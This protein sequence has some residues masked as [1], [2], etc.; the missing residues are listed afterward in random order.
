MGLRRAHRGWM[1]P[2]ATG[3]AFL[4]AVSVTG[5]K[6]DAPASRG[7]LVAGSVFVPVMPPL[8]P[9]TAY[10][11]GEP[12]TPGYGDGG[13]SGIF[14]ETVMAH[15]TT[16][17]PAPVMNHWFYLVN[18]TGLPAPGPNGIRPTPTSEPSVLTVNGN[19]PT[20][21]PNPN[22]GTAV[23]L[24]ALNPAQTGRQLWK[25]VAAANGNF[26]LRS[27]ESFETKVQSGLSATS[28]LLG[29]GSTSAML[30]LGNVP[31]YHTGPV[32]AW[33]QSSSP[34]GDQSA[35]QQWSYDTGNGQLT[36]A[37]GGQLYLDSS[38]QLV[39]GTGS[40]SPG[41]QWYAVPTYFLEAVVAQANSSPPFPA[42]ATPGETAAY[43]Y[44][45]SQLLGSPGASETCN[46]EGTTYS[47]IRCQY[48]NVNATS[49]LTGCQISVGKLP[50]PGTFE[51][52]TIAPSDWTSVQG[53][54]V[55]EC[56]YAAD[57]QTTFANYKTFLDTLFV[58]ES[59]SI[60]GLAGDVG[61][62]QATSLNPVPIEILE[63]IVYTVLCA[64]G[65]P[66]AGVI[67][68]VISTAT[69]AAL[70]APGQTLTHP[71]ATTV[72]SI[73]GD[74]GSA[75]ASL[76]QGLATAET[77]I[78]QDW[79]RLRQI[80][81]ATEV[82]GYN[83]LGVT[84]DGLSTAGAAALKGYQLTVMQ[85]LLAA[86]PYTL[87]LSG[88]WP[89][90]AENNNTQAYYSG[91]GN[92]QMIA[93]GGNP[94]YWGEVGGPSGPTAWPSSQVMANDIVGN[95]GNL[96]EAFNG[97]NGWK[98]FPI[99]YWNMDCEATIGTLFNASPVDL[100]VSITA[101]QGFLGGPNCEFLATSALNGQSGCSSFTGELR[102][103]GYLPFFAGASNHDETIVVN[104]LDGSQ[105]VA[106]FTFGADGC[107]AHDPTVLI[108]QPTVASG[109]AL[110][111]SSPVV[112]MQSSDNRW[113][114]GVYVTVYQP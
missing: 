15:T 40:A 38:S 61:V 52:V 25:A 78:L 90:Y 37:T 27:A 94:I 19:P 30:D 69:N 62:P 46:Y 56:R 97:I 99:G 23:E 91:Y 41:N 50:S 44:I 109:W 70:S 75:F 53:Q 80:G 1:T 64:T 98:G 100:D 82:M 54:I 13:L 111:P 92:G 16:T 26:Y 22:G 18:G 101:T 3:A 106:S 110:S 7:N 28:L 55:A 86:Y 34:N 33:N 76:T 87:W 71:L 114:G 103:Y 10:G 113:P 32:I 24:E 4:I 49:T 84:A 74:L 108:G 31:A 67:A 35:F 104:V 65:D 107:R 66:L 20:N 112:L 12:A 43:G 42:A 29:W 89:G 93:Y 60:L 5:C 95:G 57:V 6:S 45:S 39:V 79:G 8:S 9:D 96:F 63:G 14:L 36:N 85:Q 83:G 2:L 72:A 81:P 48:A 58:Q 59:A 73:Y 102:P 11:P 21:G 17:L 88:G 51:G 47:G 68:N 105:T 77:A